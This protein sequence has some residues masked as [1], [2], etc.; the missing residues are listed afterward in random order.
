MAPEVAAA[1]AAASDKGAM[2]TLALETRIKEQE[3]E[4]KELNT[5]LE[6]TNQ[7]L[8]NLVMKNG[9]A[10]KGKFLRKGQH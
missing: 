2:P 9:D 1:L 10:K 3:E 5:L 4:I 8:A 6:Q 7:T